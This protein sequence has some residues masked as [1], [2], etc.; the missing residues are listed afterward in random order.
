MSMQYPQL[1]LPKGYLSWSQMYCWTTNPKRYVK[2][3]FEDLD[4]LDTPYLRFGSNF[5]KMVE[6]LGEIM[7]RI[8][9]R[10]MAIDELAKEYPMDEYMQSVLQELDIEG[11]SE[12]QI[13]NSGKPGDMTPRCLVRGEVPILAFLDK[14]VVLQNGIG[15]YKTGLQPW[16]M[17]RVQKHEQLPYYGVGLKWSGKPIPEYAGLHWIETKETHAEKVDFWNDGVKIIRATGRIKTFH[18]EFDPRE[19]ERMEELII[20]VAWEISDAYQEHLSQL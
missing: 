16:T 13:G 2:E 3:Y 6:D 4:K 15:E 19:F 10:N 1:I 11:I 18:R 20:R 5:S 12:F 8:P 9:D 17:V 14:Y 7:V